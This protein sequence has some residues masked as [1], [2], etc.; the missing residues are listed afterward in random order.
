LMFFPCFRRIFRSFS[1]PRGI[2]PP[3]LNISTNKPR[4]YSTP[5]IGHTS[6][7]AATLLGRALQIAFLASETLIDIKAQMPQDIQKGLQRGRRR[8]QHPQAYRYFTR[9][10]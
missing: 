6:N 3:I 7:Y 9:Q 1:R 5:C 2:I 10:P 4:L 8:S